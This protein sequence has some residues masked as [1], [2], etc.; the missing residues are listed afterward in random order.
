MMAYVTQSVATY[1]IYTIMK[2]KMH[3]PASYAGV[4]AFTLI[5]YQAISGI[6][7]LLNLVPRER[8]NMHQM[9]AIITL[10]SVILMV[11]LTKVP[12]KLPPPAFK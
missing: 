9:S 7:T 1:L 5:N 6:L 4:V 8:A 3:T 2:N 12:M 10:T 11:Y